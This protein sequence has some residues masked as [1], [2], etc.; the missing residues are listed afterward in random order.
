MF[1][2]PAFWGSEV[3]LNDRSRP[4]SNLVVNFFDEYYDFIV[5]PPVSP[6]P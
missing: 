3:D 2:P 4:F 1:V 6:A 5:K